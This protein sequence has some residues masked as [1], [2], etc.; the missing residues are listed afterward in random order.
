MIN[1]K[2]RWFDHFV[3][4]IAILFLKIGINF[5]WSR[6]L[7]FEVNNT[8]G[9]G[10]G[11]FKFQIWIGEKK[12]RSVCIRIWIWIRNTSHMSSVVDPDPDLYWIRIQELPGSGSVFGIRIR[13]NTCKYRIKWRNMM[14]DLRY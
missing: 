1:I 13:I 14:S 10:S 8:H 3:A 2:Y 6:Y 7:L 5:C 11:I 9:S 12:P 4:D